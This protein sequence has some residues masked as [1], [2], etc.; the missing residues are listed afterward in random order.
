VVLVSETQA[1]EAVQR[2]MRNE[3]AQRIGG[4]PTINSSAESSVALT[5][6]GL[7]PGLIY[8]VRIKVAGEYRDLG[9][10]QAA[11]DGDAT[12]PVF[13]LSRVGSYTLA[14]I[15]PVDGS[16]RYI[17]VRVEKRR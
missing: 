14:L 4:A 8:Q 16:A 3:P 12:L 2:V 9:N 6:P 15:S 13:R 10:T 17:K 11:S 7:T 5:T 1:Q